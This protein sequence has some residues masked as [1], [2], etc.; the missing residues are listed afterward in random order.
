MFFTMYTHELMKKL[1]DQRISEYHDSEDPQDEELEEI[2][3][4]DEFWTATTD[5]S[6]YRVCDFI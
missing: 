4:F 1:Q 5:L 6:P 2:D 3:I